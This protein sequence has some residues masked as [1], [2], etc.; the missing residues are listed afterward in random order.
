MISHKT[1]KQ[2]VVENHKKCK[3]S[4]SHLL[5]NSIPQTHTQTP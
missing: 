2:T 4:A 3:P 1:E 5:Q